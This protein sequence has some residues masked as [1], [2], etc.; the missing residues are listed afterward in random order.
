M[1][2]RAFASSAAAPSETAAG[3]ACSESG[4]QSVAI[5]GQGATLESMSGMKR[6]VV[7]VV[8]ARQR[9]SVATSAA[10]GQAWSGAWT[11]DCDHGSC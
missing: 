8:T 6:A 9:A 1:A 11:A 7:Y 2:W 10:L 5:Q 4:Q 3:G